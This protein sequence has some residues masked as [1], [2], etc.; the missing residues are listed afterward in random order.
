[1]VIEA[2]LLGI[3]NT[4]FEELLPHILKR[5]QHPHFSVQGGVAA[6]LAYFPNEDVEPTLLD[7]GSSRTTAVQGVALQSL[8]KVQP[9]PS[10]CARLV[11]LTV[12]GG[13]ESPNLVHLVRAT[14]SC[15]AAQ[16]D[17]LYAYLDARK[18]LEPALRKRIREQ[19]SSSRSD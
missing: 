2:H 13:I 9:G 3:A 12:D 14:D 11:E 5:A 18:D 15:P 10:T 8:R 17:R 1:M 4:G 16:K 6:A 7:I 19:T